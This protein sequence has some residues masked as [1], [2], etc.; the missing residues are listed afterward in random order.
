MTPDAAEPP[1]TPLPS[2]PERQEETV[3]SETGTG[4]RRQR[5]PA[6]VYLVAAL[7]RRA[8]ARRGPIAADFVHVDGLSLPGP[9]VDPQQFAV[10][11][12][13]MAGRLQVVSV[14][15]VDDLRGFLYRCE[16]RGAVLAGLLA[17]HQRGWVAFRGGHLDVLYGLI[18]DVDGVQWGSVAGDRLRSAIRQIRALRPPVTTLWVGVC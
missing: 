9:N 14:G 7:D 10:W 2:G 5:R 6:A 18:D 15:D 16:D 13:T 12:E 1:V 4:A 17:L 8:A 3:A 11:Q